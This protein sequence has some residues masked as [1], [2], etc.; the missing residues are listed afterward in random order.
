[1]TLPARTRTAL[2]GAGAAVLLALLAFLFV[3]TTAVDVRKDAEAGAL[4]RELRALDA[5]LDSQAVRFASDLAGTVPAP[6]DNAPIVERILREL[7]QGSPAAVKMHVAGLRKGMAERSKTLEAFRAAHARTLQT[8]KA[9][10]EAAIALAAEANQS[11]LK[12]TLRDTASLASQAE[13]LRQMLRAIPVEGAEPM[14]RDLD[15]RL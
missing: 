3:R 2:L 15:S 13:V 8:L 4:L 1:M 10:D 6:T 14:V 9:A 5:R 7:E 12:G 11:R